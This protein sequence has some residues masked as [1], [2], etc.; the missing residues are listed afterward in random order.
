MLRKTQVFAHRGANRLAAENTRTA[1]DLALEDD[2]NGME[3]DV[4]LSR[5]E[6]AVLWHDDDL[7]R[8]GLPEKHIDNFTYAEL[9]GIN[10]AA[11]FHSAAPFESVLRLQDFLQHYRHRTRLLL[12]IKNRDAEAAA[13][14]E[15]KVRHTLAAVGARD[16]EQI[17]IS[18]FHLDSLI[19]A[20]L[21]APNFPLI[22]NMEPEQT[23]EDARRVLSGQTFLHGFCVHISRLDSAMVELLRGHNKMIAVYTCNSADEIQQALNLQVDIL[24]SDVPQQALHLR[25]DAA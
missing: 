23:L 16:G 5:D 4:Q 11:L 25:D 6:V 14:G 18:S 10:F 9:H 12:E 8:L 7:A 20:H 22:Y 3:T 24:I 17:L 21:C 2:I 19:Y 13:R 15:L 1:F